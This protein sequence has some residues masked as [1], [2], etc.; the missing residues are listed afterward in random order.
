MVQVDE[1]SRKAGDHLM[2]S[3][4]IPVQT[5]TEINQWLAEYRTDH[6]DIEPVN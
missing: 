6:K 1:I 2:R 4:Y 3:G 5:I